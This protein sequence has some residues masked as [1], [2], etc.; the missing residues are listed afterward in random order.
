MTFESEIK[1]GNFVVTECNKCNKIIWPYSEF[2]KNCFNQ[3]TVRNIKNEGKIIEYSKHQE[4]YFALVEFEDTI[5]LFGEIITG[6]PSK[7]KIVKLEECGLKNG[8]YF[9]KL[10]IKN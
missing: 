9:F 1:K 8:S 5:R 4:K 3:T 6:N 7:G 2:C 10:S